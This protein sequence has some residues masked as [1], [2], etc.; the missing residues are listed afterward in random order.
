MNTSMELESWFVLNLIFVLLIPPPSPN[1]K[2]LAVII[3]DFITETNVK[4]QCQKNYFI[5]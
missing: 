2:T 1:P 5:K 3:S 4:T